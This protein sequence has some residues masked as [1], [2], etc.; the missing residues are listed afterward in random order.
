MTMSMIQ[1]VMLC[2]QGLSVPSVVFEPSYRG[3]IRNVLYRE[4][5]GEKAQ[6]MMAYKVTRAA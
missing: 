5:E 3:S 6:E 4:A 2:F 1:A